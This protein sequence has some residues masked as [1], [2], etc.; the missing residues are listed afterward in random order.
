M[1]KIK[2]DALKIAELRLELRKSKVDVL[3]ILPQIDALGHQAGEIVPDLV[4]AIRREIFFPP[5]GFVPII[6][7]LKNSEL[8]ACYMNHDGERYLNVFDRCQL[9]KAG[10]VREFQ[11]N[12]LN[13][14]YECFE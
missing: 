12:L 10:F 1:L 7:R 6:A 13:L 14:L 3:K 5:L 9:L 2:M 4:E 11:Q 8:L